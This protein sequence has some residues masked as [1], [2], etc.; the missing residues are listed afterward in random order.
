VSSAIKAEVLAVSWFC[1]I[2]ISV[3]TM[4]KRKDISSDLKE[5]VVAAHQSGKGHRAIF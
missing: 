2:H 4:P 5:A 1:S 3:N